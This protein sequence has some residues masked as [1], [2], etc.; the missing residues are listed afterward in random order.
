LFYGLCIFLPLIGAA[1]AGL[2]GRVLRARGAQLVTCG[3]MTLSVVL[4]VFIFYNVAIL[5]EKQTV[6]LFTWVVSGGFQIDWALRFDTLT[7]VMLIVVTGVS[8]LVHY[9]SIGY[10]HHDPHN[11]RFFSYLSLFTFFYAYAGYI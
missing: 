2:F 4:A 1:F 5:G 10:M 6:Q 9:Y 3:A 8:T 11:P 7:A